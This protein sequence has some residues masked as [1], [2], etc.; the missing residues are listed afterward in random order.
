MKAPRVTKEDLLKRMEAGEDLLVIDVRNDA[1]YMSSES[2]LPGAVRVSLDE[3][4][5]FALTLERQSQVVTYCT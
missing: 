2:R 3:I 5:S 1:D 4:E